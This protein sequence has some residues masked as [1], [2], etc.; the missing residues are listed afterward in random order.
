MLF[1]GLVRTLLMAPAAAKGGRS[2]D[3]ESTGSRAGWR[4]PSAVRL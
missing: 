4:P 1:L 2:Q 3:A